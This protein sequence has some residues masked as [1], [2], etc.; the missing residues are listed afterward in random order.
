MRCLGERRC[1]HAAHEESPREGRGGWR[2]LPVVG[3]SGLL[4]AAAQLLQQWEV[5]LT[6]SQPSHKAAA[7]LQFRPRRVP[8]L[9]CAASHHRCCIPVYY[10]VY[11]LWIGSVVFRGLALALLL[12]H[13]S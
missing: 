6:P 7:V 12:C 5:A 4:L 10:T 3:Y 11:Y 8:P 2:A 9:C 13:Y 1:R